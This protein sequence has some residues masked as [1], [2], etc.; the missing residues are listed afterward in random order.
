MRNQPVALPMQAVTGERLVIYACTDCAI[1]MGLRGDVQPDNSTSGKRLGD[2]TSWGLLAA[3]R[4]P[5]SC[6]S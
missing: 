3:P 2:V 1:L 5:K 4:E 6:N